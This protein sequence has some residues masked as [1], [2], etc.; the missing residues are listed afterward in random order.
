MLCRAA[1]WFGCEAAE[2][3]AP[4]RCPRARVEAAERHPTRPASNCA[5]ALPDCRVL[6]G[7]ETGSRAAA[8]LDSERT[9]VPGP[10]ELGP[11]KSS[12]GSAGSARSSTRQSAPH[13]WQRPCAGCSR[14]AR[15]TDDR[16][17]GPSALARRARCH[18]PL[19]DIPRGRELPARPGSSTT[20]TPGNSASALA[21][22]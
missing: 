1:A 16:R 15:A 8:R 12:T 11:F 19:G 2:E 18:G 9:G 21:G 17:R 10:T 14:P 5:L 3:W 20:S 7:Q 6:A 4:S 13:L 22:L